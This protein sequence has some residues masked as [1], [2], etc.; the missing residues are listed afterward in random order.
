MGCSCASALLVCYE[1]TAGLYLFLIVPVGKVEDLHGSISTSHSQP[2]ATAVKCHCSD[3]AR[4]V[5]E[6]SD[7]VHLELTHFY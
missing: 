1:R 4:H 5:V 7:T 3:G 6:E 2:V